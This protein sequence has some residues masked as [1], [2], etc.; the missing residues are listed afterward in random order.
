MKRFLTAHSR[1]VMPPS[2]FLRRGLYLELIEEEA[3]G[4]LVGRAFT[5]LPTSPKTVKVHQP[6]WFV[7]LFLF[8]VA[9]CSSWAM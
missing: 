9:L 6:W 3:Y 7:C 1:H 8:F 5:K 2:Q 4:G